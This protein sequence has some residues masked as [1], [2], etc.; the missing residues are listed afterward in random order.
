MTTSP[1]VGQGR[2]PGGPHGGGDWHCALCCQ[3]G[4]VVVC[5]GCL[6]FPLGRKDLLIQQLGVLPA[7]SP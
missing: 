6:Y 1:E 3:L 7:D 5:S 4:V 2:Q